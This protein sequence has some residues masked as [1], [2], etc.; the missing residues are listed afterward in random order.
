M[1]SRTR[2]RCKKLIGGVLRF[3][4]PAAI[5][6]AL[7]WYMFTKIDFAQLWYTVCHGVDY[8]YILLAMG[9]SVFSHV[10]RAMR[11]QLQLNAVGIRTPLWPLSCSIFGTYALNL[12]FPRLGEVWR[13]TYVSARQKAPFAKVL[14]TMVADRLM[15]TLTVFLLLL[16]SL[17]VANAQI[18]AFMTR[19]PVG[20][21][22]LSLLANPW[23]WV[24]VAA[25]VAL[26][27]ALFRMGRDN[28]IVKAIREK[29]AE[30]WRGF[31]AVGSMKGRGKFLLLTLC[32]WGC[33]FLQLYFAF[34]A[35]R[36]TLDHCFGPG[37]AFGLVPCLVAFVLSSIGM[38][39]PSNGGLG[40]WNMA[41]VFGLMLYGVPEAEGAPFSIVVWSAQTIMLVILGIITAIYISTEK[42]EGLLKGEP[43]AAEIL[44][45]A[46]EP[47][48]AGRPE[49]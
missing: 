31:A 3:L 1:Q 5:T 28:R 45:E 16:L 39:V 43:S 48:A 6:V 40:P 24:S 34:F 4:I 30:I 41:I 37:T 11:W 19:Y 26:V 10:F 2:T 42:K 21:G 47:D 29:I 8:I 27:W 22:V 46:V 38:A 9:V 33:Y 32:I 25:G 12:V 13:C 23:V 36:C 17:V 14:G 20:R 7:V 15:D 44:E 18:E 49:R 35:F